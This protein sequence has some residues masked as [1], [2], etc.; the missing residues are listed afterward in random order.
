MR[1]CLLGATGSIGSAVLRTLIGRGHEIVALA[2]SYPSTTILRQAG[3]TVLRGDLARPE[4]WVGRIAGVDAVV[5]MACDFDSPMAE[6]DRHLLDT[7]LSALARSGPKARFVYTGGCWLFGPTGGTSATEESRFAPLPAF[8]WMVPN[9]QRVLASP[10]VDGLV[11]HPGMVHGGDGGVFRR[12]ARD[13]AEGRAVRVT[14]SEAVRWPLVHCDDLAELYALVLEHAIPGSSWLGVANDGV[15]V[16]RIAR[17][18]AGGKDPE[19]VSAGTMAAELGEWAR[20]YAM[21]QCLSGAKARQQLGW[22]PRHTDPETD[23][24]AFRP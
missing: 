14:G 13:A 22:A 18:I 5:H 11:V 23:V 9:L 17:A 7:L 12:F 3:A 19:V 16:G 15:P 10:E 20:G 1:V 6:I 21:D 24:L 8:A 4:D 2:R